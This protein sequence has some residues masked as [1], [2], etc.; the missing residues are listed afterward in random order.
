MPMGRDVRPSPRHKGDLKKSI[1][2]PHSPP[3]ISS[4]LDYRHFQGLRHNGGVLHAAAT[5]DGGVD[6]W[7]GGRVKVEVE[8]GV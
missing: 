6:G 2:A 5:R 8:R 3:P 1:K 4:M 7:W